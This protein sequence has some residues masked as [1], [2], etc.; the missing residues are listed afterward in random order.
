VYKRA[1]SNNS[2]VF[3]YSP[4]G[5]NFLLGLGEFIYC[6]VEG[7]INSD[8]NLSDVQ[9]YNFKSE[10]DTCTRLFAQINLQSVW[11]LFLK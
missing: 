4:F 11:S 6:S 8:R 1:E 10:T 2:N 9:V 5:R 3:T 7:F